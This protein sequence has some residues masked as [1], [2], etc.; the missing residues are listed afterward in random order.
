MV[1]AILLAVGGLA[2]IGIGVA[3]QQVAPMPSQAALHPSPTTTP[4][5]SGQA[6]PALHAAPSLVMAR[7][8]PV[9]LSIPAIGVHH[10]LMQLGQN[11]DGTVQVPPLAHVDVPGWYKYSPTPGQIGPAVILGHIDSAKSGPG[12][13]FQLGALT[14]GEKVFVTRADHSTAVFTID[15]LG[16]YPKDHFPTVQVYGTTADP[17]LRLITCGGDFNESTGSYT[18]NT[19]VYAHLSATHPA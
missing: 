5:P 16:L 11:P 18:S 7:S 8:I 1:L 19:V 12:V 14:P 10:R 6:A 17:Q 2:A 13:F 15:K 4:S 9:T 3:S